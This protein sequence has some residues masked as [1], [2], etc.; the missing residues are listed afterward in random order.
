MAYNPYSDVNEIY[1]LKGQWQTAN[2]ANNKQAKNEAARKAQSYYNNLRKSGYSDIAD[3]LTASNYEQ[4]KSIND[5]WAKMSKTPTRDYLYSLGT[6]YGMSSSDIDKLI[7][8]DNQTGEVSF[9]GK[10]IGKPDAEV[11][12]VSYWSDTSKLDDAFQ[13]YT[14]RTNLNL[15]DTALSSKNNTEINEKIN[16]LWGLQASDHSK[17]SNMW[18]NE[19]EDLKNT[20]PFTTEEAKSILAKY[21]LAG[22]QGRDNAVASNAGTNGGNIDS[23]AA[24]NALRQ[25]SAL[26]NQGQ[27]VVLDAYQQK[28]DN[29]KSILEGLG[30]YQQNNYSSMQN[31]IN[32][33]QTEAQRLFDNSETAK[34]NDVSRKSEIA[35]I[36]GYSPIEWTTS[37]NPYMNADGTIKSQYKDVDFSE[38][39]AKAKETGNTNAYNA[40]AMARYYKIMN[41]Y[42]LYGQYD[43]G[44]Y[45]VPTAQRTAEYDLTE[46]QINSAENIAKADNAATLAA[47]NIEAASDEQVANI[48]ALSDLNVANINANSDWD[49][50]NIKANSDLNVANINAN[51]DQNVANIKANSDLD[52]ANIKAQK[53]TLTA[54]QATTAIKNGE[55][56][57][58]VIDAYNYYYG[59]NYTTTNPPKIGDEFDALL[60]GI[61]E[62]SNMKAWVDWANGR[63]TNFSYDD[64]TGELKYIGDGLYDTKVQ[65]VK[66]ALNDDNLSEEEKAKIAKLFDASVYEEALRMIKTGR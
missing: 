18:K 57:Q 62:N 17:L 8:W 10:K 11:D 52:V 27:Q 9:G 2:N 32:S 56:S 44:N 35:S 30:V 55:T 41:N 48:K 12:G 43:D 31:T 19:Y 5:K 50:A 46:K 14:K 33:Q 66:A 15:S 65:L 3:E 64:Y 34:N 22:L 58:N 26:V 13:D 40:A 1:K 6:A 60:A 29:A 4:A 53:P 54:S 24:A 38:I 21:D 36:T 59:T 47:A 45:N 63:K 39:M 37:T 20:N 42:G 25:Q 49:V 51:S 61:D 28:L 23:F 7:G 16:Q